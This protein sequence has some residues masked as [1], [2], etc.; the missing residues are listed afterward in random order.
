MESTQIP[1]G[2]IV[3]GIDGSTWS[4][5]ALEWAVDQA[6]LE[7]RPL[8]LVHTLE[9]LGFPAA[10][11]YATTGLDD[12]GLVT[13]T[14]DAAEDLIKRSSKLALDR[15]PGLDVHQVLS[16]SDARSALLDLG[17][18]AS[19]IVL[20]SRGLGPVSSLLLGSVSV[21][22]SKHAACPVVVTRPSDKT[23]PG[24]GI[25]VGVDGTAGSGPAIEFA[26]GLAS[27]RGLP[28]TVLHCY[29]NAELTSADS[30]SAVPDLSDIEALVAESLAGMREKFPDVDVEIRLLRGFADRR[31]VVASRDY[32]LLVIGHH[33]MTALAELLHGSVAPAVVEQAHTMVAVVPS[34][35]SSD[36][37]RG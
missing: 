28:L 19:M 3:V 32:A 7:H 5:A 29:W 22:V 20:G 10:A 18:H 1:A 15:H 33:R 4:E 11:R 13:A 21:A 27:Q 23:R 25:A 2:S 31:L 8:T 36:P 17:E 14:Q 12:G 16:H 34:P 26:Y 24:V 35:V 37:A 30:G 6:A 9:P